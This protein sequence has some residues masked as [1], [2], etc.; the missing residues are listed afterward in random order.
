[1]QKFY[2]QKTDDA[3]QQIIGQD[4]K[5]IYKVLRFKIN[6]L[7][8]L[9]DGMGN[10][11]TGKIKTL[12]VSQIGFE[13]VSENRSTSESPIN[14]TICQAMLK[15]KKMDDVLRY[16]TELGIFEWIPFFSERSIPAPDS[17]RIQ[18]RLQRWKTIAKE[19]LKLCQ[20]SRLPKIHSPFSYVEIL[21]YSKKFNL[22]IFFWEEETAK[23]PD[24]KNL[25]TS[26]PENI[27]IIIGPE[28][29][30]T[31]SENQKAKDFNCSSYSLGPRIM[32]AETA[33]IAACTIVQNVFG[34]I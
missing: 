11:Y 24:L 17:K 3:L 14:I 2:F 22:K 21:E 30:F 9:T 18:K 5:H 1:M 7:I 27:I 32:R 28:G 6:D 26:P 15:D 19:S 20:R 13:I 8:F 16:L 10:D 29:G 25:K 12:S 4:A 31:E 23:L 34:D 33:S